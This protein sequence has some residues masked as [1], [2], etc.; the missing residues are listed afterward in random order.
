MDIVV[1]DIVFF[2]LHIFFV[3]SFVVFK[4]PSCC[5]ERLLTNRTVGKSAPISMSRV[6]MVVQRGLV[7]VRFRTNLALEASHF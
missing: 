1:N 5:C 2:S 4:K 7:C 3:I 6:K